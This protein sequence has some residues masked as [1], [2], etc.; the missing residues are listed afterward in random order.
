MFQRVK[1]ARSVRLLVLAAI[2]LIGPSSPS[3][4]EVPYVSGGVGVDERQDLLAREKDFNLKIIAAEASGDYVGDV[5]VV[6]ES[7]GKERVLETAMDGPILL[8]S[9]APGTYTVRATL[10]GKTLTRTV[11]ISAGGLRQLDFRWSAPRR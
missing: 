7:I 4:A 1:R 2:A 3:R 6:I 9:L 10:D 5:R 11:T 8:A